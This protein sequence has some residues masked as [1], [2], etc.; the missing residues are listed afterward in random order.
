[1]KLLPQ[2]GEKQEV[3]TVCDYS[4]NKVSVKCLVSCPSSLSSELLEISLW[5]VI[6][7]DTDSL[8]SFEHKVLLHG[9]RLFTSK[10]L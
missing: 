7:V 6:V 3:L 10:S 1:M 2:S 9:E 8:P 4:E 5:V